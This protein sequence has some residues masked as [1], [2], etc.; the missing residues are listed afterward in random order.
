MSADPAL[1][2]YVPTVGGDNSQLPGMGGIYNYV[3]MHLYHYA[4][5]NP[6]RYYDPD[7][8][9]LKSAIR[10][11]ADQWVDK[12]KAGTFPNE[13]V[14]FFKDENGYYHTLFDCWQGKGLI[15]YNGVYDWAFDKGTSMAVDKFEFSE[16]E[17]DYVL[18]AWKGDYL[19]LGAGAEL[20]IY[21][22]FGPFGIKTPHW[23][24]DKDLA[25]PM[26]LS[27]INSNGDLVANYYPS[28]DNPQW[29]ITGFNPEFQG[30][31]ANDLTAQFTVD[32]SG[33]QDMYN[34]LQSSRAG[35]DKRWSFNDETHTAT[36]TF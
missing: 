24:V 27:L 34:A 10:K 36:F 20:G 29:W 19:N 18:W 4:G 23:L 3:N 1:R 33:N 12:A 11:G 30:V 14:G 25:M 7:G 13:K 32:F 6:V 9:D 28:Q 35:Q 8:R 5:N 26:T 17:T 31:I 16:G 22:R 2:E 15:G 21:T